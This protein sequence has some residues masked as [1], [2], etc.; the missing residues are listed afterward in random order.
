LDNRWI[1]LSVVV[2]NVIGY[3]FL[4]RK[5]EQCK[6]EAERMIDASYRSKD[7]TI[8]NSLPAIRVSLDEII[9]K[10]QGSRVNSARRDLE[11]LKREHTKINSQYNLRNLNTDNDLQAKGRPFHVSS[12]REILGR[13]KSDDTKFSLKKYVTTGILEKNIIS[14]FTSIAFGLIVGFIPL[15][16]TDYIINLRMIEW[17]DVLILIGLGV[18]VGNLNEAISKIWETSKKPDDKND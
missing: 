1:A 14:G 7:A 6:K 13:L 10:L 4:D 16:Q 11:N 5:Q 17:T 18:G 3:Y 9:S 12:Y 2:W 15:L 8:S